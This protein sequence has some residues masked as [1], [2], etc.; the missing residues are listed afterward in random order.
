MWILQVRIRHMPREMSRH[1]IELLTNH[2]FWNAEKTLDFEHKIDATN[3]K[4][5][6]GDFFEIWRGTILAYD[7]GLMKGDAV[8]AAAVWRQLFGASGEVDPVKIALVVAYIRKELARVGNL[9]DKTLANGYVGFGEPVSET[10]ILMQSPLMRMPFQPDTT[11][12]KA[13]SPVA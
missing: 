6:L 9:S 12:A 8:M 2:F 5:T 13:P 11:A 4:K 10:D 1:W 3:R 7:E